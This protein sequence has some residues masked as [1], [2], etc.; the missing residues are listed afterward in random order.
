MNRPFER[1][2]SFS[3]R[4][5]LRGE[6]FELPEACE[7]RLRTALRAELHSA[8]PLVGIRRALQLAAAFDGPLASPSVAARIRAVLQ[9]DRRALKLIREKLLGTRSLDER[10]AFL[11]REGR[12]EAPRAP[13][14]D[15]RATK[16]TVPLRTLL[17]PVHGN[18]VPRAN[19]GKDAL[20]TPMQ[21]KRR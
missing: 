5:R 16:D 17:N 7:L 10:R 6:R 8:D 9:S 18:S 13:V 21:A 4:R 11:R 14:L 20:G 15:E 19:R 1:E 3:L 12:D 2:V